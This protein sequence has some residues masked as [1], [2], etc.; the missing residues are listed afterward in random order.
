MDQ[1]S[2]LKKR[3]EKIEQKKNKRKERHCTTRHHL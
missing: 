2:G 1:F 3:R